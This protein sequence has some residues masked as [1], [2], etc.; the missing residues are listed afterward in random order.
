MIKKYLFTTII[1][2]LPMLGMLHAE[3][4]LPVIFGEN[5][6]FQR[7]VPVKVWGWADKNENVEVRFNQQIQKVRAS[8]N[9]TW[10]VTLN[11]MAYGGPYALSVKGKSNSIE[12][13]NILIGDIWY[14][15]GQS[16]M[17][18][19]VSRTLDAENEI[20][21]AKYPDIRYFEASKLLSVK[22][23]D[24]C[25]GEW[26]I[27]S[28]ATAGNFT[29]VGFYFARKL[30]QELNVPIGI[31]HVSW[32]GTAIE[33]WI[34]KEPFDNLP[35]NVK[36]KYKD[37]IDANYDRFYMENEQKRIGYFQALSEDPGIKEKWSN[38]DADRSA[39]KTMQVPALW[40]KS[41]L[42]AQGGYVWFNYDIDLPKEA[43]N[44]TAEISLGLIQDNDDTYINGV[45]IGG[46]ADATK[47]RIYK[48]PA[49]ILKE[50]RNNL[51]VRV[52]NYNGDGG[53]VSVPDN[54]YLKI[55]GP[56]HLKYSLAGEWKYKETI[57]LRDYNFS[58]D[59]G[60][61]AA[62][63]L[64]YNAMVHPLIKFR[65]K[66][67]I[68]YQ[69]ESNAANAHAYRT[70][71]PEMINDYRTLWGYDFSFYWV[72]LANFRATDLYPRDNEW[73]EVREAQTMTLSLP[74]TGQAVIYDIGE[75]D[76]THPKN[77]QEV[78]ARL[79]RI[80]LNKDYGYKNVVYAGPRYNGMEIDGNRIILSFETSGSELCTPDKYG[81][82]RGFAVA[83]SDR[84]FEWAQACIEGDKVIVSCKKIPHPVAVRYAWSINPEADLQNKEGLL[85][86]PFRTD[87]WKGITE[88]RT[89]F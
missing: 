66:G 35:E 29:A 12:L 38:P 48:I 13:K 52:Y 74:Y 16:N 58:L 1:Y 21:N 20:A 62:P 67:A 77:K 84:K 65:I 33:T 85:A 71:F 36:T 45:Y 88:G 49:G 19:K 28:P 25:K 89:Q 57:L 5:M 81:Y 80:A 53:M 11:A 69:G 30:Y 47:R 4:R 43:Q 42:G 23:Q 73:A 72:Q 22:P 78:G 44:K 15:G 82:V 17:D 34:R 76:N 32:G 24:D 31:L 8:K 79:A 40:S 56:A 3:V 10:E 6:V 61:N 86:S 68:W 39:W 46:I 55:D 41:E 7:D 75:A 26:K 2:C 14:C 50:G 83:G 87:N 54:Y 70:L 9:G 51:T 63:S 64:L 37:A 60:P 59:V 27:C 18:W